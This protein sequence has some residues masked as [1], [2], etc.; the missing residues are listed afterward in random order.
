V[1][2][3]L[4]RN[5]RCYSMQG[6]FCTGCG[7]TLP[8]EAKK[9][10]LCRNNNLGQT[11]CSME[12]R[13][14]EYFAALRTSGLWPSTEPFHNCSISNIA[15]R[16]QCLKKDLKH[17]CAVASQCPLRLVIEELRNKVRCIEGNV[18]DICL[19]CFRDETWVNDARGQCHHH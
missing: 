14:A 9:C 6:Q 13:I 5:R 10:G 4:R 8:T 15:L 11:Y 2:G 12:S 19:N 3:S 16:F 1:E 17:D 18:R 7:S